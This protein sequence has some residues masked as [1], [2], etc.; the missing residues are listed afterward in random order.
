[1][2][3]TERNLREHHTAWATDEHLESGQKAQSDK[4]LSS[5]MAL[6]LGI[7]VTIEIMI[8]GAMIFNIDIHA[9]DDIAVLLAFV[10]VYFA[11]VAALTEK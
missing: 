3:K 2:V 6:L 4:K 10:V 8:A 11:V 5:V 7:L 1:M 9:A